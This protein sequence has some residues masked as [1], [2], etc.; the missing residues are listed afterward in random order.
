MG[1]LPNGYLIFKSKQLTI[2]KMDDEKSVFTIQ[3]PRDD[4]D[5]SS[6]VVLANGDVAY[7][8]NR[9]SV[10]INNLIDSS[11]SRTIKCFNGEVT[12]IQ[13]LPQR[14]LATVCRMSCRQAEPIKIWSLDDLSLVRSISIHSQDR[15]SQYDVIS[16]AY[17]PKESL[18]ACAVDGKLQIFRIFD[19]ARPNRSAK[20]L[21][22][23][24]EIM[25]Y[26]GQDSK[27]Q[28]YLTLDRGEKNR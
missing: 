19:C 28:T 11:K 14:L 22:K 4:D 3:S 16:L 6:L 10:M 21:N 7:G 23:R 5:W 2:W 8:L 9:G 12:S 15:F 1:L 18:L 26:L 27:F 17:S 20:L 13:E 25:Q 24:Y